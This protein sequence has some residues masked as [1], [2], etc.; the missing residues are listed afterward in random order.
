VRALS[1]L[2]VV[3]F[4]L[5]CREPSARAPEGTCTTAPSPIAAAHAPELVVMT[6]A[7]GAA[8]AVAV[9]DDVVA[10]KWGSDVLLWSIETGTLLGV[11]R[12]VWQLHGPSSERSSGGRF[13]VQRGERHVHIDETGE[14]VKVAST[15]PLAALQPV[16]G[17]RPA[18]FIGLFQETAAVAY[19]LWVDAGGRTSVLRFDVQCDQAPGAT[20]AAQRAVLSPNGAWAIEP[21]AVTHVRCLSMLDSRR[22]VRWSL[23]QPE[24]AGEVFQ[25]KDLDGD[26]LAVDHTGTRIVIQD[27]DGKLRRARLVGQEV[28]FFGDAIAGFE[29]SPAQARFLDDG[30]LFVWDSTRAARFSEASSKAE[31]QRKASFRWPHS[32]AA[33]FVERRGELRVIDAVDGTPRT[34]FAWF[35]AVDP[36]VAP[37]W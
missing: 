20:G 23:D 2:V 4:G 18:R 27:R 32:E 28:A 1:I 30:S 33:P 34:R 21:A 35:P 14:E 12:D 31:W 24:A 26:L 29:G 16:A 19:R 36:G 11:V 17:A 22:L 3:L 25:A 37:I 15:K 13:V 9:D 5:S 8:D 6:R 10:V 7:S